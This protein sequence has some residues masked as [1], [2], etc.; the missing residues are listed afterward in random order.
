MNFYNE[1]Y[2]LLFILSTINILYCGIR[3]FY[4]LIR[5]IKYNEEIIFKLNNSGLIFLGISL[6]IFIGYI[7]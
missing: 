3:F 1:V 6:S 5:R 4:G 2:Q 7:I